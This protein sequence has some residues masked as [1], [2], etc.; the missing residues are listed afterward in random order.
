MAAARYHEEKHAV[1]TASSAFVGIIHA[2]DPRPKNNLEEKLQLLPDYITIKSDYAFFN[3]DIEYHFLDQ[4]D[5]ENFAILLRE[6]PRIQKLEPRKPIKVL[7]AE[8][9]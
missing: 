4:A 5:A 2:Q 8:N 7:H 3:G 6:N 1:V 9:K